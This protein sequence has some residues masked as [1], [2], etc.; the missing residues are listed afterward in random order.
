M[1][2]PRQQ[3]AML[4][5]LLAGADVSVVPITTN[6]RTDPARC[7][8]TVAFPSAELAAR[9]EDTLITPLRN[10]EPVHHYYHRDELH[11]TLK[12]VQVIS[13]PPTYSDA[14]I[15]AVDAMLRSRIPQHAPIPFQLERLVRFPTSLALFATSPAAFGTL[16]QDLDQALTRIG[17]PDNK[18]YVSNTVF[19]GNITLCRLTQKPS[20]AFEALATSLMNTDLGHMLVTEATLL[21]GNAV[22]ARES[23]IIVNRYRFGNG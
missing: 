20:P 4:H 14:D 1:T 5:K 18:R 2:Y 9:I 15:A 16:V 22:C 12:G 6:H 11:L 8:T 19:F 10:L 23:R 3:R 7:L 13:N 17:V 21:T